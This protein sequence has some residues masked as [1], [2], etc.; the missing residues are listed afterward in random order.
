[1]TLSRDAL[2]ARTLILADGVIAAIS[3]LSRDALFARTLLLADGAIAAISDAPC[4]YFE[5]VLYTAS[6]ALGL[7]LGAGGAF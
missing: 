4:I 1:M 6:P 3:D 5:L 2:F 7:C